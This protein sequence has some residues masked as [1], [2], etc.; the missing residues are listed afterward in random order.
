[1]S[2]MKGTRVVVVG[3]SRGFGRAIAEALVRA[4][5]EVH[6]LSRSDSS[7]LVRA[8][9][10]QVHTSAAT[11]PDQEFAFGVWREDKPISVVLAAGQPPSPAPIRE[12][13]WESFS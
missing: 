4:G 6:A 11:E 12:H 8:T 13:T 5:A 2:D 7:E 10:G 3:A 9:D 1:M